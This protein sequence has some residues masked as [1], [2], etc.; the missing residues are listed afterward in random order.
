MSVRGDLDKRSQSLYIILY[1]LVAR[2]FDHHTIRG[3]NKQG[4]VSFVEQ[5]VSRRF[6]AHFLF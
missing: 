5:C 6:S 4:D 3:I 2:R 1:V